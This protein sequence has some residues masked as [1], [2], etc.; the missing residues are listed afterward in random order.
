MLRS[1]LR[2]LAGI[3]TTGKVNPADAPILILALTS[4]ILTL[5]RCT[6]LPIDPLA[7]TGTS[8]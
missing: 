2:Q 1:Q 8:E 5:P 7:E 3:R 6:T 4:D